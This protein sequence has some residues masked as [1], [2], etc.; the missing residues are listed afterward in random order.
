MG[1]ESAGARSEVGAPS[2]EFVQESQ[3][4]STPQDMM[5]SHQHCVLSGS[6]EANV[7]QAFR[8][9]SRK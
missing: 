6:V 3:H 4:M 9:P 5:G 2:E 7:P 1:D 8:Q